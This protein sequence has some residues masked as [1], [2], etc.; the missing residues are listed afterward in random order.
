MTEKYAYDVIDT[1]IEKAKTAQYVW[2]IFDWL[3]ASVCD[4]KRVHHVETLCSFSQ[5]QHITRIR[6]QWEELGEQPLTW[7][8]VHLCFLKVAQKNVSHQRLPALEQ[9]PPENIRGDPLFWSFHLQLFTMSPS[10]SEECNVRLVDCF[11]KPGAYTTHN[12]TQPLSDITG[13]SLSEDTCSWR[14]HATLFTAPV[15]NMVEFIFIRF[16]YHV[17]DFYSSLV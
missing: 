9:C 11:W 5:I 13:V 8:R 2:M 4:H 10:V 3:W 12:V 16:V 15:W 17:H 6:T 14:L 1:R 7:V